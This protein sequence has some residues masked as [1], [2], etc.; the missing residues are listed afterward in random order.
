HRF[1][2]V[3]INRPLLGLKKAQIIG[4]RL[5]DLIPDQCRMVTD[6]LTKALTEQKQITYETAHRSVDGHQRHFSNRVLPIEEEEYNNLLLVTCTDITEK[7]QTES[8]LFES[9]RNYEVIFEASPSMIW[10]IDREHR[11]QRVNQTAAR[12]SGLNVAEV[13]GKTALEL[14]PKAFAQAY[15][16]TNEEIM[17]SGKPQ[18]GIVEQGYDPISRDVHWYRTDKV[19]NTDNRGHVNGITI[20]VTDITREKIALE[21]L[22]KAKTQAEA[23]TI[24]KSEFLTT[25]SHEI[26]T[27][28]NIVI[29]MSDLLMESITE[30]EQLTQLQRLQNAGNNL[31]E[32]INNILDLSR[33]EAG[34]MNLN[35]TPFDLLKLIHETM[36]LFEQV[37]EEKGIQLLIH[38][39]KRLP[40]M[41]K[42]D[43][44]AIRR[45]F[46]NLISNA[47]KF[48]EEGAVSITVKCAP[49]KPDHIHFQVEDSGIGLD[50]EQIER[51]FE[52]FIQVESGLTRRYGGSGLGLSITK[53]L[54]EL[55]EGQI[56][57]ESHKNRGSIFYIILP[58]E[59]TQ[60][61]I[62]P[63]TDAKKQTT[64]D[65]ALSILLVEDSE[66]NCQLIKAFLKRT[67]HTLDIAMNGLIGVQCVQKRRYDIILMDMQMP[68]MDGYKA[69]KNIRDWEKQKGYT[70]TPILALTAHALDGDREKSLQSGCDVHL[71]KPIKKVHLLEAI[72]Q[73]ASQ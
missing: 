69:T 3:F 73:Y 17:R 7:K 65:R 14:F 37:A 67:Q 22:E 41:V 5:P 12:L 55:M 24:A 66:D 16:A 8:Q 64:T 45:I 21:D 6:A 26:R 60:S 63:S 29:G 23:A 20:F 4:T 44:G 38:L 61:I 59:S 30:P 58:L 19:P 46:M 49:S 25:M 13:I 47:L 31:L 36:H 68:V 32:L 56:W 10:Y 72:A 52:R 57:V 71:T 48:T 1:H 34:Q 18:F 43:V 62:S 53:Q 27:P 11:V 40:G 33:I 42:G 2:I 39:D 9:Q 70:P 51:I 50:S 35:P 28:M 15:Q 54:V